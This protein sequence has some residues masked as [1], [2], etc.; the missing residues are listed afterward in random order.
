MGGLR[1]CRNFFADRAERLGREI[2][3]FD[4]SGTPQF[5]REPDSESI[6]S[7]PSEL[8]KSVL[9]WVL[10]SEMK[11]FV[12]TSQAYNSRNSVSL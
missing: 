2:I 1:V 7:L 3:M 4:G 6:H 12:A 11:N 10:L 8:C 9:S 5:Q